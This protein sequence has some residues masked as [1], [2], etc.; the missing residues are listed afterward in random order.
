MAKR[1]TQIELQEV[2]LNTRFRKFSGGARTKVRERAKIDV[3]K[4]AENRFGVTVRRGI[5]SV[6]KGTVESKTLTVSSVQSAVRKAI[7]AG[8]YDVALFDDYDR[9]V[10]EKKS[11]KD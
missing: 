3:V 4:I 10:A 5:V 6:K 11:K 7:K 2:P 9:I 1:S 8:D